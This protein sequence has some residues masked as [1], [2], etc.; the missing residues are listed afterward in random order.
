MKISVVAN[1]QVSTL[2]LACCFLFPDA[3]VVPIFHSHLIDLQFRERSINN[4][5]SSDLIFSLWWSPEYGDFAGEG[6]RSFGDRVFLFP[7]FLF[8]GFHPD[9]THVIDRDGGVVRSAMG[10]YNSRIAIAA[11]RLGLDVDRTLALFNNLVYR[12]LGYFDAFD[13]AVTDAK[14]EYLT[15]GYDIS[16]L[17][18][19]WMKR[20]CFMHSTHHPKSYVTTDILK[21]ICRK[22]GVGTNLNAPI[23]AYFPDD[24][25]SGEVFPLYPELARPLGLQGSYLFKPP[26]GAPGRRLFDLRTFVESSFRLYEPTNAPAWRISEPTQRAIDV[27]AAMA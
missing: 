20:G 19:S 8:N 23:D 27:I 13:T 18:A 5:R 2:Q 10:H 17:F 12:R 11:F 25:A 16:P 21:A 24:T 3:E 14:S 4:L 22:E 9:L 6:M 1:C 7:Q 26:T 15:A